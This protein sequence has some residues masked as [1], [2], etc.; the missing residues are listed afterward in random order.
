MIAGTR[1][2]ERDEV[3]ASIHAHE[4]AERLLTKQG[5]TL[6]RA[7]NLLRLSIAQR[8]HRRSTQARTTLKRAHRIAGAKSPDLLVRLTLNAGAN[9]LATD[10]VK[11]ARYWRAAL[12]IATNVGL[13]DRRVHA[14][15]DVGYLDLLL[16]K[17]DD[18]AAHLA[19]GLELAREH[20][21]E[22]SALRAASNL[23]CVHLLRGDITR[24]VELL[25]FAEV[26]GL[27]LEIGRRLWRVRSNLATAYEASGDLPRAYNLDAQ[28]V[29]KLLR[30]PG[31]TSAAARRVLPIL[32]ILLRA[33]EHPEY[34][35]LLKQLP[36]RIRY[37]AGVL[38]KTLSNTA[39]ARKV[40]LV[41]ASLKTIEGRQRFIVTE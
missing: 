22:N 30:V 36:R 1:A 38:L 21:L 14:M 31:A 33:K 27:N 11:T 34:A 32:N 39:V 29:T 15:I 23:A 26:V 41:A 5:D 10:L 3:M 8:Q 12:R 6:V 25:R 18:A 19:N 13:V 24:A 9:F 20:E 16:G 40:P 28:F 4:E 37:G 17:D 35:G 2:F 7:N